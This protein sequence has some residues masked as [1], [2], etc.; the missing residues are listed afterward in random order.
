MITAKLFHSLIAIR[1]DSC[2][3]TPV[4]ERYSVCRNE[5]FSVQL[6]YRITDG[7][8]KGIIFAPRISSELDIRVYEVGYVPVLHTDLDRLENPLPIGL[9][10]D[11][12]IPRETNP[13]MRKL[14]P[15]YSKNAQLFEQSG[16][17]P[18][19]AYND[20]WQTLWLTVNEDG[21]T[22]PAGDYQISVE[23]ID[24]EGACVG[25][26]GMT[27]EVLADKLPVQKQ[28]CTNWFHCDCLADYYRVPVFSDRFFEI[29]EDYARKA[30]R[31][32]MNMILLPAFT[33][34]LD[35]PVDEERMTV[36]L[37]KISVRDGIYEFDFS[38]L[39]KFIRICKKAGIRYFEHSHL[40]TQ[41]GAMAAPKIVATVD[42]KEKQIFGWKTDASGKKYRSFLRQYL[43]AL[44]IVLKEE[45]IEKKILF[46]ISD[47]PE[48]EQMDN[49]RRALDGIRDLLQGYMQG[50]ALSSYAF[51]EQGLVQTAIPCTPAIS[52][53]LGNCDN[54]WCYYIGSHIQDGLSNRLMMISRH[55]NR[56]LGVQMYY[57]HVKGFLH[58]GY[59]Y[60]YGT[61]SQ[62]LF[63]PKLNPA[64]SYGNAGTSYLVY[65]ANDGT[66]WQS[67]R[68][69]IFADG[70]LDVR[71]LELLEKR[72][73]R[74]TCEEI[75]HRFFGV[76]DFRVA[77][78]SAETM[79]TFR[80]AVYAAIK[81]AIPQDDA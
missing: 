12:L 28:I 27:L 29:M 66:A 2:P 39:R 18:L 36:Q 70:F 20:S 9:Y 41:W 6:A 63:D 55:R 25:S 15:G 51:Y 73:G 34:P 81:A 22:I 8:A 53:F 1:P 43:T 54:L 44:K 31:N 77:P 67:I 13:P 23:L 32:G 50:D 4:L 48:L 42:G 37:V 64:S 16:G 26:C 59:N 7:S 49:Y 56:M 21:K 76:P 45:H 78:A 5:P 62:G 19:N 38:L 24:Q 80:Q 71:A 65:P 57:H 17:V 79:I 47:E 58:W 60:Y 30:A 46:H 75:I 3:E 35:T 33:P 52:A 74:Q 11:M 61:L 69:K 68:Q 72:A 14:R 10:P 40:F